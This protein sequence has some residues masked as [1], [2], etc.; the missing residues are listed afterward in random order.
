[1]NRL[2]DGRWNAQHL[3]FTGPSLTADDR[4]LVLLGDRGRP[5]RG[6][7]DPEAA[8]NIFVLDR[9]QRTLEP[10]SANRDGIL[11]SY[12]YFGG[13]QGR[14]IAPGSVALHAG[15]GAV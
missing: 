11:R 13:H 9:D 1:V 8:L 6:P 10:I 15:S 3:Y 12:V 7:Y 2:T 14:G 4:R 5:A